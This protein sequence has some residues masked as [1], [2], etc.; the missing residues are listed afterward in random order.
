MSKNSLVDPTYMYTEVGRDMKPHKTATNQYAQQKHKCNFGKHETLI[1]LN[2]TNTSV[3]H[4]LKLMD[5]QNIASHASLKNSLNKVYCD[6]SQAQYLPEISRKLNS[7]GVVHNSKSNPV[8]VR[9]TYVTQKA[10]NVINKQEPN[11]NRT[12]FENQGK[13]TVLMSADQAIDRNVRATANT[14]RDLSMR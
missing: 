12:V 3:T 4:P 1:K 13:T 2:S 14:T 10:T 9:Q 11:F 5:E 7:S 6:E 8:E